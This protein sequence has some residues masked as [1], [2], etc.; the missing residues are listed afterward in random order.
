[1]NEITGI[2]SYKCPDGSIFE[3][4]VKNGLRD[5]LGKYIND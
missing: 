1:M 5:G 3:G 4:T 2:G